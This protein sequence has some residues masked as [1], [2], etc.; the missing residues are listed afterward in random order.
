MQNYT[1][2]DIL[3]GFARLRR[4][5]RIDLCWGKFKDVDRDFIVYNSF[6]FLTAVG[7]LLYVVLLSSAQQ[8]YTGNI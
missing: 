2:R 1:E 3:G 7:I 4:Y 8:T 5:E 6:V